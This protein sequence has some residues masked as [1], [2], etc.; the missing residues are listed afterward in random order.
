MQKRLKYTG[1][2]AIL[3]AVFI[4]IGMSSCR[5]SKNVSDLN[6]DTKDLIR[7][8]NL[9]TSDSTTIADI[10]WQEY[11]SDDILKQLIQEALDNNLDMKVAIERIKQ[12]EANFSMAKAAKLPT[13]S[14]A[15]QDDFT[16]YSNNG[17]STK[18]LGYNANTLSLGLTTSWEVDAWGKLKSTKKARY[19]SLLNTM[20][21]KNLVQTNII[22]GVAQLY[23]TL[24]SLDEQLRVTKETIGLLSESAETMQALKDAGQTNG[25]AVEQSKA[26]LYNTQLSVYAIEDQIQQQEN[27]LCVLLGKTPGTVTRSA[28]NQQTVPAELKYGVP[29]Q[30]LSKRPDVLSAELSFRAA[31][32]AT[33]AAQASLYPGINLSSGS[34]GFNGTELSDFFKPENIA[35]NF[36]AGIAQPVFYKKQLRGSLAIAKSQQE[37][38]LL[39]F[40]NTVLEAGQEVSDILFSFKSSVNKNGLR[41]KQIIALTNAVDFTQELLKAGEAN[42]VEVLSAQQNLLSAQL[43]QVSDKLEQLNYSVA[44]Y[45]ALGGG[46]N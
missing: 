21:Y 33:N 16:L 42:Y 22:A 17:S 28:I 44:L 35:A 27:S 31:F 12:A 38:A 46:K 1:K 2:S 11:F 39:T 43:S 14:I 29:A 4:A 45:K 5:T 23:Y 26:L 32:E 10:P 24:L 3:I 6:V 8:E 41:N 18:V 30:L 7:D 34:I 19:A 13:L 15:A 40:K 9:N 25:A 20:E 36:V 37:E